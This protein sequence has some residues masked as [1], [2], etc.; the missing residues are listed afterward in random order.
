MD[1]IVQVINTK[2]PEIES[3]LFGQDGSESSANGTSV[4]VLHLLPHVME[5]ENAT[6]RVTKDADILQ[7]PTLLSWPKRQL[8]LNL[9]WAPK[10]MEKLYKRS[11]NR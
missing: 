7:S 9:Y 11:P 3:S 8:L 4:I 6:N 1:P 2:H 5:L 10:S